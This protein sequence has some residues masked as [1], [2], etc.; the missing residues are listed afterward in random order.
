MEAA[1]G[2]GAA[3]AALGELLGELGWPA[4]GTALLRDEGHIAAALS[5][6]K[7]HVR[8]LRAEARGAGAALQHAQH[9]LRELRELRQR[10]HELLR[11][12][13]HL[14]VLKSGVGVEERISSGD[15]LTLASALDDTMHGTVRQL[16]ACNTNLHKLCEL[17][18]CLLK[19]QSH[20]SQQVL[21]HCLALADAALG[22]RSSGGGAAAAAG[23]G[24]SSL[25]AQAPSGPA[26][27]QA[28]LAAALLDIQD[29][30]AY[31]SHCIARMGEQM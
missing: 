27:E 20:G 24:S 19:Q 2:G 28:A 17:Q 21:G 4:E 14:A 18:H 6:A 29:A 22:G 9:E 30:A 11:A 5:S 23:G 8:T 10:Q 3:A 12:E 13:S 15:T 25:G 31:Q 26:G 7:H 16:E 1:I